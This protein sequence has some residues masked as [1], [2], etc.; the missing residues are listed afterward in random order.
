MPYQLEKISDFFKD[1]KE[2]LSNPLILSFL[3][4]WLVANWR[5]VVGLVFYKIQDLRLDGYKSYFD[6]I[7]KNISL[8]N[9]LLLPLSIAFFYTFIFPFIRNII[10]A[11]SAWI[12]RWGVDWTLKISK[13]GNISV[14]KYIEL[15]TRYHE[16]TKTLT[17][18]I[19]IDSATKQENS[20]LN[21]QLMM[22]TNEKK[23]AEEKLNKYTK[24]NSLGTIGGQ[25]RYKV[26]DE[27]DVAQ[28]FIIGDKIE[29]NNQSLDIWENNKVIETY[30]IIHYLSNL[31]TLV[32]IMA[33][34]P[35]SIE[36]DTW[37]FFI[38]ENFN[39][40]KGRDN[41][42][43]IIRMERFAINSSF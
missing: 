37:R 28:D 11:F 20:A 40:L 12:R 22:I 1:L 18:V 30:A 38:E 9:N 16:L 24:H 7:D 39:S 29:I 23:E 17:E 25:W 6:L 4:A 43:R 19:S 27:G 34:K 21:H 8:Y 15:R 35:G 26:F 31:N 33:S 14:A 10:Q 5:I 41:K 13:N 42:G 3:I 36:W 32:L 2:R